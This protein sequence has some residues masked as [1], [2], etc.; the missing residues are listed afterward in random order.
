[1]TVTR[2]G[3]FVLDQDLVKMDVVYLLLTVRQSQKMFAR[4]RGR[5][6]H[7][8]DNDGQITVLSRSYC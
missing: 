5:V 2:H 3:G 4:C 7:Y 1:V 8:V 6:I